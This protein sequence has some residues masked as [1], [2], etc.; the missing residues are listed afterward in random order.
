MLMFTILQHKVIIIKLLLQKQ[1]LLSGGQ[2][3]TI[4]NL[5]KNKKWK[6]IEYE[7]N[8]K[9]KKNWPFFSQYLIKRVSQLCI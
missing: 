6:C 3:N 2:I 5:K 4:F 7:Q 9:N 8:H 1:E